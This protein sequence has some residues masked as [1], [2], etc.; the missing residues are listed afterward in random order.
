MLVDGQRTEHTG[1]SRLAKEKPGCAT[2]TLQ[3]YES[4]ESGGATANRGIECGALEEYAFLL[5]AF[6]APDP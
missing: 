2:V 4:G 5:L 6:G 1:L 3:I